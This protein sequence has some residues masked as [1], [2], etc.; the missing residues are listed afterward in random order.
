MSVNFPEFEEKLISAL[1]GSKLIERF[2]VSE[3]T[4]TPNQN[5]L[6]KY[7]EE[8]AILDFDENGLFFFEGGDKIYC[9]EMK[10]SITEKGEWLSSKLPAIEFD[11]DQSGNVRKA[12]ECEAMYICAQVAHIIKEKVFKNEYIELVSKYNFETM[13][14]RD[15]QKLNFRELLKEWQSFQSVIINIIVSASKY[16]ISFTKKDTEKF[17]KD[18]IKDSMAAELRDLESKIRALNFDYSQGILSPDRVKKLTKIERLQEID[19]RDTKLAELINESPVGDLYK[20]LNLSSEY[21]SPIKK[22]KISNWVQVEVDK[23]ISTSEFSSLNEERK[24]LISK[25]TRRAYRFEKNSVRKLAVER[26]ISDPTSF[27]LPSKL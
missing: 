26:F 18:G 13:S 6:L 3:F 19:K 14:G 2:S 4:Q 25:F 17:L 20:S 21:I 15:D 23:L 9:P 12:D 10:T 27:K 8:P 1:K 7:F 16:K 11:I 24:Q 22:K 5:V